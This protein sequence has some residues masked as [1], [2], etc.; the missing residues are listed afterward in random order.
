MELLSRDRAVCRGCHFSEQPDSTHR[1]VRAASNSCPEDE[2]VV[3]A[4]RANLGCQPSRSFR[5][6]VSKISRHRPRVMRALRW[7]RPTRRNAVNASTGSARSRR[8]G[9]RPPWS[10]QPRPAE[11]VADH[12]ISEG[13]AQWNSA[14]EISI[15][16]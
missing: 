4:D 15:T 3:A 7:P 2:F 1:L 11:G 12:P 10:K 8:P 14:V 9:H 16:Y 5:L 6:R 13:P